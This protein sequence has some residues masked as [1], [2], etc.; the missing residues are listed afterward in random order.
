[1]KSFLVATVL[2]IGLLTVAR[3]QQEAD[4]KYI[5]IYGVV[6]QA[7]SQTETGEP[8]QA[9]ASL[10]DAQAQLQRFQKI[11]PDWNPGIITY[12]LDDL[13]KKIT[14]IQAQLTVAAAPVEPTNGLSAPQAAQ[15]SAADQNLRVQLQSAQTE[16]QTLQ[17]KLKEALAPQP[18]TIDASELTK[19]QEQIRSLMK[20]NDLLK[21]SAIV[22]KDTNGISSLRQQLANALDKYSAEEAR[23]E[24]LFAENTALQRDLK[25]AGTHDS[26]TVDLLRS[27]N[28]RLKAQLTALQSAANDATAA[29]ELAAKLKAANMQISSLQST[30]TVVTLEKGALE[31]KVKQLNAEVAEL[32]AANFEGR[33]RDLT[34]QRDELAKQIADTGRKNPRKGADTQLAALTNEMQTLRARLA[35]DEAKAVPYS[36]AELALFREAPPQPNP[37]PTKRSIHELPSGTAELVV[38]AQRHFSNRE[39]DAAEADYQKILDR[40]QNNG[41]VLANMA[42]IEL[43][44]NK[45]ADAEKHITAALVQSPDDAYNLSTLGYLKFRQEKYDDALDV[46]SRA[47]KID[48]NNPEIQ[49]YLGVTLSHKGLRVQAE[50]A[51]RKAIQINPLYAPAHN[52]LAVVYLN[53]TP[54]MPMLARWHYQKAIAAGQPRNP[55]LEKLLADKGAPVDQ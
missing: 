10:L 48:P 35:V 46:L 33:I 17:A 5:A 29:G 39:F 25:R 55:D 53:Q 20:E 32:R 47:A 24:K 16:N 9:L 7:E 14:A 19:A 43:Q 2:L 49:N 30:V 45:L 42:T 12:R 15:L 52:N 13:A 23:A 6:Q 1:M 50:T 22:D 11:Y 38:S 8:K 28:D 44:E 31:N 37:N 41:L 27:E 18:A 51:L 26:G 21:A 3:A 40:D 54:A 36:T 34:E 4:E